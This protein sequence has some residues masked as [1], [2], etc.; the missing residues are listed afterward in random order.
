MRFP[1]AEKATPRPTLRI[2]RWIGPMPFEV[3]QSIRC[4]KGE[5]ELSAVPEVA[6]AEDKVPYCEE[7]LRGAFV[8]GFAAFIC[9]LC[10][11]RELAAKHRARSAAAAETAAKAHEHR[12]IDVYSPEVSI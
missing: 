11:D 6:A 2:F 8:F 12:I 7:L 3:E 1:F 9:D 4:A 10:D 5:A